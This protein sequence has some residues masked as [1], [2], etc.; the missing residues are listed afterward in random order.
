MREGEEA[1]AT[2][3]AHEFLHINA[4]LYAPLFNAQRAGLDAIAYLQ[5]LHRIVSKTNYPHIRKIE[6]FNQA[7]VYEERR[8]T[9]SS[10]S[11]LENA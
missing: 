10:M 4:W 8:K 7:R 1:K 3:I 11:P 2:F 6:Y 5:Q 9:L